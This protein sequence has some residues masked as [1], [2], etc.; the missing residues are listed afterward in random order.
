MVKHKGWL[1]GKPSKEISL[2][3]SVMSE[4]NVLH[5]YYL[6]HFVWIGNWKG[7]TQEVIH[8]LCGVRY[9][10]SISQIT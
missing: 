8:E 9:H 2:R 10:L 3:H 6:Q 5:L 4:T 7:M 1:V